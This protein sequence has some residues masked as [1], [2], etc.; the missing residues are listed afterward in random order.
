LK[1]KITD[2]DKKDWENFILNKQKIFDKDSSLKNTINNKKFNFI[3]LH[4][5]SLE[6]A[7]KTI[8]EY[9]NN[10]YEEGV[11]KITVVTGKGKRS[12]V[13]DNPYLSRE[14]S[15]LKNSVPEFIRSNQNLMKKIKGISEANIDD[16]SSGAFYI[17]LKDK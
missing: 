9:I 6:S 11:K 13:E 1:K 3:D 4:G 8:E 16:G 7:N 5:F 2:K 14:L 17:Y 10:S 12:K 15:I